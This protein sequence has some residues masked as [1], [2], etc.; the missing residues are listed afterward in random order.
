M[1]IDEKVLKYYENFRETSNNSSPQYFWSAKNQK[2]GDC[3]ICHSPVL[4]EHYE[5]HLEIHYGE[6][7]EAKK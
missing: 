5:S 3:T 7:S 6:P 1:A 2:W 4:E